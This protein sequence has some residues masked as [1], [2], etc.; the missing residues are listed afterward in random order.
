MIVMGI[1]LIT[2]SIVWIIKIN[3]I[4]KK[5]FM[6]VRELRFF[7]VGIILG[8]M[9][10]MGLLW[11][12]IRD[13]KGLE[14]IL[15]STLTNRDFVI[16]IIDK[17]N[18]ERQKIGLA[19]LKENF[20]LDYAASLRANDIFRFQDFSHEATRS[21][22]T[23]DIYIDKILENHYLEEGE[24]L[25]QGFINSSDIITRWL[26]S[27]KHRDNLLDKNYDEIGVAALEGDLFGS[28][29]RVVVQLFGQLR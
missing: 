18:A 7:L 27:P 5:R 12:V 16:S 11:W 3:N 4:D 23:Y 8:I 2:A 20:A 21:G 22:I 17:T 24:N 19:P 29:R 26:A 6:N 1:F 9:V 10:T 14:F 28:R 15:N 25:A 13:I